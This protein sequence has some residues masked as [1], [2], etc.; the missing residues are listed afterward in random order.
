MDQNPIKLTKL[1]YRSKLLA[2]LIAEGGDLNNLLKSHSIRD[3]IILLNQA[4]D[5]LPQR[6][7]KNSWSKLINWDSD[8]YD[9]D[10]DI[11]IAHLMQKNDDCDEVIQINQTL[12]QE[13]DSNNSISADEIEK[14]NEDMFENLSGHEHSSDDENSDSSDKDI[15]E[16][17]RVTSKF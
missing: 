10:D 2:Q 5:E 3:A 12:L 13:I 6:V 17:T 4:W 11:P 15:V 8:Q 7:L 14:W 9:S 16:V 1:T